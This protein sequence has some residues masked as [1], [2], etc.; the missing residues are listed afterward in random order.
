MKMEGWNNTKV[1]EQVIK[2]IHEWQNIN[3]IILSNG[4]SLYIKSG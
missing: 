1:Q 2:A 4:G 3:I